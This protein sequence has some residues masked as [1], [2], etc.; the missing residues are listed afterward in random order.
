MK[1]THTCT[2]NARHRNEPAPELNDVRITAGASKSSVTEDP[3]VSR[4][5]IYEQIRTL[6][7]VRLLSARNLTR[8]EQVQNH[9]HL[10]NFG[11][12]LN[13]ILNWLDRKTTAD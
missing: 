6:T 11:L 8:K 10:G 1:Q 2:H 12:F 3:Y 7:S 9:M 5:Q 13:P 4:E